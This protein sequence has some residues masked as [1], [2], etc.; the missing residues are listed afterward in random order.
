MLRSQTSR[1]MLL[2]AL[3]GTAC[4]PS[5]VSA[6]FLEGSKA[7]LEM[8]NFY[9]NRDFRQP[10]ATQNHAAEW[11][12]GFRFKYESGFTEGVVGFGL[13]AIGLWGIKLDS[14]RG[15]SGTGLLHTSNDGKVQDDYGRWGV[16]AKMRFS[17]TEARHGTLM[18]LLPSVWSSDLRLLPQTFR[19]T[20]LTSKEIEG[21][22]INLGRLTLVNQRNSSASEKISMTN[23]GVTG[24]NDTD[25]FYFASATYQPIK[26]LTLGYHYSDLHNN[27]HQH[28][29]TLLNVLPVTD[30]QSLKTDIRVARSLHNGS[31][32]VDNWMMGAMLTYRI[33]GHSLGTGF[34][35]MTGKTGFAYINGSNPYLV[36]FIQIND[37]SN[38]DERSWQ[39]R[40]DYNFAAIGLPGL[41]FMS[42]YAK[43]WDF[44]RTVNGRSNGT[45]WERDTDIAYVFQSGPLR[46]LGLQWRNATARSNGTGNDIDENRFIVNYTLPLL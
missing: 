36:N 15:R 4:V 8:R 31:T 5:M 43:G 30:N 32:N 29:F 14:G 2:A 20:M 42:R 12:Q 9:F 27:Y 17:K 11:A 13:D 40:Y 21:L 1:A 28:F 24:A 3:T 19:G 46:N 33:G 34:Q 7:T 44:R 26:D 39:L 35:K 38:P 22:D 45:E 18:P 23:K 6:A 16:T 41:T 25:R 37:F 10:T